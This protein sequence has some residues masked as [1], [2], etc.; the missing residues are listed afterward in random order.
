MSIR[1]SGCSSRE[2][3]E[4]A[5][6][7]PKSPTP[8]SSRLAHT[9]Y[10]GATLSAGAT[11]TLTHFVRVEATSVRAGT[12]PGRSAAL[13]AR[14]VLV[15]LALLAVLVALVGL[16]F[17]GSTARIADGVEIAGVDVGG[18]TP[19]E[20]R[21]AAR[22]ALRHASRTFPSS[23][24][25]AASGTP[26]KATSLS[27]EADWASRDRDGGSRGRGL[28]A[29]PRLPPPPGAVLRRR[30][31]AAGAGLRRRARLQARR[32]RREDRPAPR[33]GEARPARAR[34]RGRPGSARPPARP[35]GRGREDRPGAGTARARAA[36]GAAGPHRSGRGRRPPTWRQPPVRPASPSRRPSAS[37]TTERAGSCRA[38]GSPSCCR[39]RSPARRRSRSP[40]RA[41][42]PGSRKLRK[43]VEHAPVDAGFAVKP[44][45][46]RRRPRQA[47]PRD[48][49]AG[50][51]EGAPRG[52]NV[53]HGP[54]GRARRPHDARRAHDGRGAG[55]GDHGRRRQLPHDLRRHPEPPAQRRP[56]RAADR[57][58]A[59][60]ARAR[61]SRSTA[62]PASA[63][64][65]RAS[66][67]RR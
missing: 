6:S 17:A 52:G 61:R 11:A 50:D 47:R 36:R 37:N 4:G 5:A 41:P 46:D 1:G 21:R 28:R 12:A 42:K 15:S 3:P 65:R 55:D 57:R 20:A 7:R 33:R 59:D 23:S 48:R 58:R 54:D 25:R 44:G 19:N 51:G 56:G 67:R 38:G 53:A 26:I 35:G 24:R 16:A 18:L 34:G 62:R 29:R 40:G 32:P 66:R 22:T 45:G 9:F 27:V 2:D 49:R 64:P 30:D 10:L 14:W 39:C 8:E 63:R 60:R 13:V 43:T 31:R